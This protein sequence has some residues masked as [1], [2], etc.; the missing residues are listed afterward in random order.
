MYPAPT[1]Q[2][3]PNYWAWIHRHALNK[4]HCFMKATRTSQ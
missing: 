2:C 1:K 4:L 3:H